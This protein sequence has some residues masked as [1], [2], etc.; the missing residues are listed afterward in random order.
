VF[1]KLS[2]YPWLMMSKLLLFLGALRPMAEE[3]ADTA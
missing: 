2:M 1:E 3:R